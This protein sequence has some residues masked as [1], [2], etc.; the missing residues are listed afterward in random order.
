MD[1]SATFFDDICQQYQELNS[2][3]TEKASQMIFNGVSSVLT[4]YEAS[5]AHVPRRRGSLNS[6]DEEGDEDNTRTSLELTPILT[7]LL[8]RF[9][10]LASSLPIPENKSAS[11]QLSVIVRRVMALFDDR[12]LTHII[13]APSFHLNF[14][15][16]LKCDIT[17]GILGKCVGPLMHLEMENDG[18]GMMATYFPK[19]VPLYFEEFD[20]CI[21]Y[22]KP[23]RSYLWILR[24][25]HRQLATF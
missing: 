20:F 8:F 2:D 10:S 24:Q 1:L 13:L 25:S 4:A 21:D 16:R 5:F 19:C 6:N 15:L 23:P 18:D 22:M 9:R 14:V 11:R 7:F 17:E 3:L 12:L